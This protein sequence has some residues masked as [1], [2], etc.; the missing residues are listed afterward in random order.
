MTDSEISK[1]FDRRTFVTRSGFLLAAG[2]VGAS[3]LEACAPAASPAA[4]PAGAGGTPA[5][6]GGSSA[7]VK[8]PTYI[9]FQ[10]PTPDLAGN[11]QGLD[12]A[13]F[14]F[15]SNLVQTVPTPPGDGSTVTA[16]TYLTLAPPPPMEQN[17]AWQA[18]NK[19]LNVPR[20]GQLA[21]PVQE[22]DGRNRDV[23]REVN[24]Q[25]GEHDGIAHD[26]RRQRERSGITSAAHIHDSHIKEPEGV[27]AAEDVEDVVE[28][29]DQVLIILL[30]TADGC[31][32]LCA[33]PEPLLFAAAVIPVLLLTRLM[34]VPTF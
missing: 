25:P 8:P 21:R 9:P 11:D 2:A 24:R 12:P 34:P 17:A 33:V 5:A 10:G 30:T 19:A 22:D 31:M 29:H 32:L 7:G 27:D 28:D 20:D 14:K 6:G 15:P 23:H 4:A 3:L 1:R 16:L 18:V 26:L 13:F